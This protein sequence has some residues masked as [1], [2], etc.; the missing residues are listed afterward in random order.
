MSKAER[1]K[2]YETIKSLKEQIVERSKV[3]KDKIRD[4]FKKKEENLSTNVVFVTF[5]NSLTMKMLEKLNSQHLADRFRRFFTSITYNEAIPVKNLKVF[6]APEPEDV[7]WMN[8]GVPDCEVF[9]RK[10]LTFTA[11]FALLGVS[12]GILY[13]LSIAQVKETSNIY[14]SVAISVCIQV[15][16]VVIGGTCELMQWLI[17][18]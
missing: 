18:N 4:E 17:L 16:N 10:L 3:L 13:G 6:R 9:W 15:V 2:H 1:E 8:L 5:R 14:I 7:L 11:T 12:F